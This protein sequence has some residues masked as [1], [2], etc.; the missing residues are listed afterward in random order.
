MKHYRKSVSKRRLKIRCRKSRE[1]F[2]R[3]RREYLADVLL[4]DQLRY[5]SLICCSVTY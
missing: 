3:I 2:E 1:R 4:R 5:R